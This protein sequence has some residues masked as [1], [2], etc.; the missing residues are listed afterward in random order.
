MCPDCGE[1]QPNMDDYDWG[2]REEVTATCNSCG[3]DYIL[4]RKVS[5]SYGAVSLRTCS[6]CGHSM[7]R[8]AGGEGD[9]CAGDRY[10][11]GALCNVCVG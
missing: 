7:S 9:R 5:V 10:K 8:H 6:L 3:R 4:S 2:S 1:K 11:G